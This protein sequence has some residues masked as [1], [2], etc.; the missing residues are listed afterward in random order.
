MVILENWTAI[1][2]WCVVRCGSKNEHQKDMCSKE[3]G[4]RTSNLLIILGSIVNIIG[5][6][7]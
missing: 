5:M 7:T 4:V 3:I 1:C 2:E 6:P